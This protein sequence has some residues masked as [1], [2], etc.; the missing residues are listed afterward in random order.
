MSVSVCVCLSA[1]ISSEL[2]V[3]SS[4]NFYACFVWLW[5]GPPLAARSDIFRISGFVYDVVFAHK[6]RLLDVAARLS[7]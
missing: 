4:L 5:L 1:I 6:M 2:H 3:R 7:Q